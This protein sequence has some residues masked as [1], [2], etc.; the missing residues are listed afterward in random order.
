MEENTEHRFTLRIDIGLPQN[1]DSLFFDK[2]Y[3]MQTKK[4]I[5][6]QK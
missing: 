5:K 1:R 3:L 6:V 2:K 4:T